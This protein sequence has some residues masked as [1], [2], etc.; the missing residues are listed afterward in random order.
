[1]RGSL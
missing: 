1:M